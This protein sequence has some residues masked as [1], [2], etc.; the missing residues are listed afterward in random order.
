M[1]ILE[2]FGKREL[3]LSGSSYRVD[4][5]L[6]PLKLTAHVADYLELEINLQNLLDKELL[7]SVVLVLPK[8]LGLDGSALSHEREIRLGLL[9]PGELKH[10]KVNVYATQRTGKAVY[11]AYLYVISH[12]RDYGYVLSEV[13]KRVDIR[14]E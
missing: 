7:T 9:K 5:E 13:K 3:N 8:A 10:L 11:P 4:Y 1:G 12:Y 6:H 2:L 14:V